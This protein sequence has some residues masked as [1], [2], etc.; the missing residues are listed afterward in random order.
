[1]SASRVL[2]GTTANGGD[3]SGTCTSGCS[4]VF[5]LTPPVTPGGVWTETLL[6]A[7]QGSD[8]ANP[9]AP[10][11][12]SAKGNLYGAARNGGS[13]GISAGRFWRLPRRP[14]LPARTKARHETTV[15]SWIWSGSMWG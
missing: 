1:M 12:V 15:P 13:S 8:G 11:T 3:S 10:L 2:Y 4:T 14:V 9:Y 6:H 7:F 5:S